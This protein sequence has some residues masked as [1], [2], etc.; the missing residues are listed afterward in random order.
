MAGQGQ[1][2]PATPQLGMEFAGQAGGLLLP[3]AAQLIEQHQA[4]ED[5]GETDE[6]LQADLQQGSG[7]VG[8][9]DGRA[10]RH[11]ERDASLGAG[12][13]A[14]LRRRSSPHESPVA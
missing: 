9:V 14:A 2:Q 4:P 1:Q 13:A 10:R 6:H 5:Q 11:A 8:G 12:S 7:V 3:E